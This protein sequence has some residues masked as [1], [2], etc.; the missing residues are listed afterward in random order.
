[1]YY[2]QQE[3]FDARADLKST[4]VAVPREKNEAPS[5]LLFRAALQLLYLFA[6]VICLPFRAFPSYPLCRWAELSL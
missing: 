3:P 4:G 5:G 1:M 6:P 2:P